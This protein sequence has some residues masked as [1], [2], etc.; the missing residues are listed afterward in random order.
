MVNRRLFVMG[1]GIT[2]ALGLSLASPLRGVASETQVLE[3]RDDC[4]PASFNAV[5]GPGA[6]VGSGTTTF[7]EFIAELQEDKVASDWVF[8]PDQVT[9]QLGESLAIQNTG[10]GTHK[11]TNGTTLRGGHLPARNEVFGNRAPARPAPGGHVFV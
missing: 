1:L 3:L 10:G 4:D 5:L 7:S 2:L 11:I 8:D 6:C 9:I